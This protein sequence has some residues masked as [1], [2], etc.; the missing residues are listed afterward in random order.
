M[1]FVT[2]S[3]PI[4]SAIRAHCY[5]PEAPL[6][7]GLVAQADLGD[8]A[9]AQVSKVAADLVRHVRVANRP[10]MMESF[11]SEYGLSTD[12]GI[13][14]MCLAEALLRVPDAHTIDELISDKI[15]PG[16]WEAHLGK[17]SSSL[18]NAAT[19]AL[20]LTGRVLDEHAA[21]AFTPI[22]ALRGL[23]RRVGEPVVRVAVGQAM[24][25]LGEQFV[26]GETIAEG[27]K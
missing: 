9:R 22:G 18:V 19:W 24:R 20:L 4:R 27:V 11:L 21:S 15:E 8:G 5:A 7:A 16:N 12:E 13:G 2:V 17:S 10:S 3:E 26:L 25:I 14:L 23:V 1:S 6:V